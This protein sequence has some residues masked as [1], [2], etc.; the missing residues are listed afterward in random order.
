MLMKVELKS[1]D[2]V[3]VNIELPVTLRRQLAR[4]SVEKDMDLHS[5][6]IQI[7]KSNCM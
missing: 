3:R 7:L 1:H 4:R 6:I 2:E 5:L